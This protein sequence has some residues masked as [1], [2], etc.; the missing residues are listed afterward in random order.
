MKPEN[1]L[2]LSK[3]HD[4]VTEVLS[5]PDRQGAMALILEMRTLL[6][7]VY[8]TEPTIDG[9]MTPEEVSLMQ[10]GLVIDAIKAVR[11]RTHIGLVDAKNLVE[12]VG[13][14]MGL[15][16]DGP[17]GYHWVSFKTTL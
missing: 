10:R 17:N 2:R 6:A 11:N 14:K 7:T 12:D 1:I 4:L 5:A 15:R 13:R 9:E 3:A 8:D 16:V